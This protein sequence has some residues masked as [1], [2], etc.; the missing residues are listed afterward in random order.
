VPSFVRAGLSVVTPG[1]YSGGMNRTATIKCNIPGCHTATVPNPVRRS[2]LTFVP[3]LPNSRENLM[4]G[5]AAARAAHV[6]RNATSTMATQ[7]A[8]YFHVAGFLRISSPMP[9]LRQ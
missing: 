6:I 4:G 1:T 2:S 8:A 3:P 9:H 7:R 5:Y